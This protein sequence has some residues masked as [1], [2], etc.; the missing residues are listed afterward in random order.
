MCTAVLFTSLKSLTAASERQPSKPCCSKYIFHHITVL[1]HVDPLARPQL[2]LL[3]ALK[4]RQMLAFLLKSWACQNGDSHVSK[5]VK[6]NPQKTHLRGEYTLQGVLGNVLLTV[7]HPSPLHGKHSATAKAFS[8]FI[9]IYSS[10]FIKIFRAE[11]LRSFKTFQE[12][13]GFFCSCGLASAY[14]GCI[15]LSSRYNGMFYGS[16]LCLGLH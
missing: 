11:L 10:S 1:L 6:L 9:H 8:I 4:E 7:N 13:G 15:A 3:H 16:Q 5:A 12:Y 2:Q 14:S